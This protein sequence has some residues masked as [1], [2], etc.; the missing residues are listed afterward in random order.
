MKNMRRFLCILVLFM[1]AT[2][3]FMPVSTQPVI[4][5]GNTYYVST[6][7]ND[8]NP[9]TKSQPFRTI[10]KGANTVQAGDTV[11]VR[12]GTYNEVVTIT[13]SGTSNNYITIE[14]YPGETVV[15]DGQDTLPTGSYP[16][17]KYKPMVAVRG[18]FVRFKN[19]TVKN[20]RG[21]GVTT[22]PDYSNIHLCDLDINYNWSSGVNSQ[23]SHTTIENCKVWQCARSNAPPRRNLEN[24]PGALM[25]VNNEYNIVKNCEV[26]QN[27]GEGIIDLRSK[28][29]II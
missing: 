23:A 29:S 22:N 15:I 11:F 1:L 10:Q 24:W 14:G 3:L 28:H 12:E 26:Y 2:Q 8:N 17:A 6:S 4:A 21:R 18:S 27:H 25:V 7:G 9:G 13:V 19:F 5:A 16:N 20:S